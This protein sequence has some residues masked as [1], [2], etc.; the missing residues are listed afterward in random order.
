MDGPRYAVYFVPPACSDLYRFG[1]RLLGYDCY[2]GEDLGHPPDIGLDPP[3]WEEL[4]HEPRRYGFHATLKAPFRLLSPFSE[5]DLVA[6]LDRFAALPRVPA[7]IEP[8][9]RSIEQFI[10]IVPNST[11][12]ALDRLAADCVT[13]F[14]RMR[15]PLTPQERHKRIVAGASASQIE[16][17]DRWGYP[18]VFEDFRFHMTLTGSL[19]AGGHASIIA[20]LQSRFERIN[21]RRSLPIT[22]IALVRQEHPAARFRVLRRAKLTTSDDC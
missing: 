5:T 2:R 10:A 21:E 11:S 1:A 15:R 3:A 18:F 8:A 7:A 12:A 9:I 13:A 4:T 22:H 16:N 17:L 20:L 19:N 14:D 6:E